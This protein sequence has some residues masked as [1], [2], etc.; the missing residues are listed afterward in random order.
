M[1]NKLSSIFVYKVRRAG[2]IRNE[3]IYSSND[4]NSIHTAATERN[5]DLLK[6]L[7]LA[8]PQDSNKLDNMGNAPLHSLLSEGTC[9][10]K[11]Y[12]Y[13]SSIN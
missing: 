10:F 1:K 11:L 4:R 3:S 12:V 6:D 13:I 2:K 5:W 8:N 9:L 7:L